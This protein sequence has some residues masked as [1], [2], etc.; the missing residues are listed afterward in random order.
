M[1]VVIGCPVCEGPGHLAW[2]DLKTGKRREV[3]CPACEG[4]GYLSTAG[5]G[6]P[7]EEQEATQKP[8][9]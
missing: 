7:D 9:A 3:V 5:P 6:M 8:S 2:D 1:T 4:D